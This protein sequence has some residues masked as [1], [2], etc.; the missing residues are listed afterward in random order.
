MNWRGGAFNS[1][2]EQRVL[3]SSSASSVPRLATSRRADNPGRGLVALLDC[4]FDWA[5]A[6]RS[7]GQPSVIC[8]D[9]VLESFDRG[10][11]HINRGPDFAP[12]MG[13]ST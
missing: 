9:A 5:S 10:A 7:Q 2:S 4:G 12:V 1:Q 11:G 13:S 6:L 3:L 8:D